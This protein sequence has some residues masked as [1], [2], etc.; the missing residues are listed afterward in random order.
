MLTETKLLNV[1]AIPDIRPDA[2]GEQVAVRYLRRS[3]NLQAPSTVKPFEVYKGRVQ[4]EGKL[5][6]YDKL[7]DAAG[8]LKIKDASMKSP[9]FRLE[10][11][12]ILSDRTDLALS[13]LGN[14][15]IQLNTSDVRADID[16]I[17]N[18]GKFM[19]NADANQAQF[20]SNRYRCTFKSFTWYMNEAYLN[21]GIE[22]PG[23]LARLWRIEVDSLIP[24]HGK[25]VFV[26]TDKK[27]D[28]LSFIAPLAK[29]DLKNGD[30]QCQWVNHIDVANGRLY[31]DRGDIYISSTGDI[32]EFTKARLLCER[33]D[34]TRNLT[35]VT[36]KLVG[37]YK[38]SGS[39]DIN[40][41]NEDKVSK[42]LRFA[43]IGTDTARCLYAK[44]EVLPED[45]FKLNSGFNYKGN[46]FLYSRKPD[47]FFRG[48][49]GLSAD[50]T[51]LAHTWMK[52][53]TYFNASHIVVPTAIEN[54]D[55]NNQRI[56]NGVYLNVDKTTRPYAA[57]MSRRTFY[58][59]DVV[60][61]GQGSMIW[62]GKERKYV[63]SDTLADR[64]YHVNYLPGKNMVSAYGRLDLNMTCPGVV[65]KSVGQIS[66]DLKEEQ[67]KMSDV[68]YAVDFELLK[69]ME[70]VI[71]K[72]LS[73]KKKVITVDSSLTAKLHT[74][75]GKAAIPVIDKQLARSSN[76]VPDSLG[77]LLVLDSLSFV[78]N[79]E[80]KAYRAEGGVNVRS[81]RRK[82]VEKP[83]NVTME[84]RR[85]RAG[86][87]FY[88][89]LY[90]DNL[91][92]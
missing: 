60:I 50:A 84:V 52:V 27:N 64:H 65:Q 13:S 16:M 45:A 29:Y 26:S 70:A 24:P 78:W 38:F 19:N 2:R 44:A 86:D 51:Y 7:M 3:D 35:N 90:N 30:I 49:V 66:Y 73:D 10:A 43:E 55:D 20:P 76:N 77:H 81:I 25:N 1:A 39:G 47:L 33:T 80:R 89:Y 14:K 37:K 18:K 9:L 69:K 72:D 21:I 46:I 82:P 63:I 91:W 61:G 87:E 28:S 40:Y 67:L 74:L 68:L 71:Q 15:N 85:R 59:D 54:R 12:N 34:S 36:F 56:F 5:F 4:H 22:D 11:E 62:N 92:Y 6:V 8:V 88:I 79:A 42:L 48:Y 58:N 75:Y 41:I 57:F 32:K 53:N 23:L 83:L 31:P 17:N